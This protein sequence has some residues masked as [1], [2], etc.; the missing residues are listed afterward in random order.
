MLIAITLTLTS[1]TAATVL[2]HLGRANYAATLAAL[3]QIHLALASRSM[4]PMAPSRSPVRASSMVA[5]GAEA[6]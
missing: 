5:N 3:E 1:P 6:W 2:P 4:I